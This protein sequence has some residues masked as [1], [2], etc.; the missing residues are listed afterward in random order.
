MAR[1]A[2]D[3]Q[4]PHLILSKHGRS[5]TAGQQMSLRPPGQDRS[6]FPK[7]QHFQQNPMQ[8]AATTDMSAGQVRMNVPRYHSDGHL[9]R[10]H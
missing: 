5:R 7:E 9:G 4:E 1:D 8:R 6:P 2:G 3:E 10:P